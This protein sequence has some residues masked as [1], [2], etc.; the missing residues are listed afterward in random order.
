MLR[1]IQLRLAV[2]LLAAGM[3]SLTVASASAFTRENVGS[4][5]DGNYSFDD[6][7]KKDNHSSGPTIQPL[8]ANGPTVQFGVQQGPAGSFGRGSNYDTT[9][10]DP[11]FRSLNG[12]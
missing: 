11:Y 8:G 12:R 3:L 2:G 6:P 7:N 10:P 5:G 4:G 9:P 1:L